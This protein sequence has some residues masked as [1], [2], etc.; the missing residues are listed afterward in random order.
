LQ[1]A[2]PYEGP[3]VLGQPEHTVGTGVVGADL[4]GVLSLE[5]EQEGDL[6]EDLGDGGFVEGGRIHRGEGNLSGVAAQAGVL[7][8]TLAGAGEA[9]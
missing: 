8:R 7:R 9:E 4:E 6:P 1:A 2:F 5:L 3:Q